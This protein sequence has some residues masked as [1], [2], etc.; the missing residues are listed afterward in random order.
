MDFLTPID[1]LFYFP[2]A[3]VDRN[4]I[5]SIKSLSIQLSQQAIINEDWVKSSQSLKSEVTLTARIIGK[6][7]I[8]YGKKRKMLKLQ[9]S[10]GSGGNAFVVFWNFVAFYSKIYKTGDLINVS[11]KP[12]LDSFGKISFNHPEIEK[13][14]EEDQVLYEGGSILPIYKLSEKMK[15]AGINTRS[16]RNIIKNI[17]DKELFALEETL[18]EYYIKQN[19]LLDI[20]S[21]V[22]NLHFPENYDKIN[23][24]KYRFKL[25]EILLFELYLEIKKQGAK[26]TE[27]GYTFDPK[28]KLARKL[29]ES[30]PFELTRDQKKVINEITNDMKSGNAMNRLLQGDVGSGKTIVSLLCM[31]VAVDNGSQVVMM[32]PTEILAEQHFHSLSN[33]LKDFGIN[34]VQLVGGQRKKLRQEIFSKIQSGEANI[35]IGTH[36]VFESEVNYKKLGF[37]VI[38]EQ[39]RFGVAQRAELK[40][41]GV[42]SNDDEVS[43]HILVMSATPIPRTL[44]LTLY[45]DLDVSVIKQ[46]PKNRKPIQTK[47]AF[48][49]QLDS[50]YDFIRKQIEEGHQAFIVYPLVEKI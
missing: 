14:D 17:I 24:A 6:S 39:H 42:K 44:S 8:N 50:I 21:A 20:K 23:E 40:K 43:P 32:A 35:I 22:K 30:L 33:Y 46:L 2:R 18:P 10:D 19:N 7:E 38:D 11:G 4:N 34:I 3:Y 37:I 49:S 12:E 48:E 15:S 27:K 45:G 5:A 26:I 29:Y 9:I 31:L 16:L 1:L 47:V 13:F 36:A 28:S 41:L 25:Q